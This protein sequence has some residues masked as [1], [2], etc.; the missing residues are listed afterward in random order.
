VSYSNRPS[1]RPDPTVA[2]LETN[3]LTGEVTARVPFSPTPYQQAKR[4]AAAKA[5]KLNRQGHRP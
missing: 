5:R 2:P 4:E 1:K 3:P